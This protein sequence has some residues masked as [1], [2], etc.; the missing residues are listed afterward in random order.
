ML[1]CK[2]IQTPK[3]DPEINNECLIQYTSI[4]LPRSA[5]YSIA[6]GLNTTN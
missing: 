4:P 2:K 3:Y 5:D 6:I 1:L